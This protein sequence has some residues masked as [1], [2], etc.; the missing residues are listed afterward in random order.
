MQALK[1]KYFILGGTIGGTSTVTYGFKISK[2]LFEVVQELC[3]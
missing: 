1:D 2:T 3:R